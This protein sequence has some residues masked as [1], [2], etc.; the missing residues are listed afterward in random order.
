MSCILN[1]Q[2]RLSKSWK[3]QWNRLQTWMVGNEV[4]THWSAMVLTGSPLSSDRAS[5][6]SV[7]KIGQWLAQMPTPFG[8]NELS[9]FFFENLTSEFGRGVST[10]SYFQNMF[11]HARQN[12]PQTYGGQFF[13]HRI[14][15]Q[16]AVC[17]A[18][19]SAMSSDG[20][21]VVTLAMNGR[22]VISVC[23]RSKSEEKLETFRM[24]HRLVSWRH[25]TINW[26]V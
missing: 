26:L 5:C 14:A 6:V 19:C 23:C 11:N 3:I 12:D 22:Q 1:P 25:I 2:H 24:H 20:I 8:S 10:I 18:V 16:L 21:T 13:S 7:L 9:L 15:V 17:R 4:L